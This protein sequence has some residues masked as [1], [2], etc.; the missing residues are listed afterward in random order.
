[1]I[2][3][4]SITGFPEVWLYAEGLTGVKLLGNIRMHETVVAIGAL[5]EA[6]VLPTTTERT[7]V[8]FEEGMKS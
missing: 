2:M 8:K 1:M 5:S 4:T 7:L 3:A 6:C